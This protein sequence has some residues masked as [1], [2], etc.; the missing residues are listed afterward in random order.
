MA[1]V[2]VFHS[3]LTLRCLPPVNSC[4]LKAVMLKIFNCI[5]VG[6]EFSCPAPAVEADLA[7]VHACNSPCHQGAVGYR[8]ILDKSHPHYLV[9]E[10][11]CD[12]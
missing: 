5:L 9:L 6:S 10:R 12:L 7:V 11:G 8:G 2:R 3:N 1:G 4:G